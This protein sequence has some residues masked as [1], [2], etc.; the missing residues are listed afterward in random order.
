MN[1]TMMLLVAIAVTAFVARA[2]GLY[3]QA[4]GRTPKLKVPKLKTFS[5]V[6]EI[7]GQ[8]W[9]R[10]TLCT[11]Y[12]D[13][14]VLPVMAGGDTTTA[15][16]LQAHVTKMEAELKELHAA[17]TKYTAEVKE[18]GVDLLS[19]SEAFE[20]VDE[21][22]KA[23]STK[24]DEYEQVRARWERLVE[25]DKASTPRPTVQRLGIKQ[26]PERSA[27]STPEVPVRAAERILE[28]DAY[29]HLV[30][31]G[32]FDS[33][34]AF[35]ASRGLGPVQ[36]LSSD[37]ME[38][39]L[40]FGATTVTGGGATSAGPFI[41]SELMPGFVTYARKRPML[42]S[43]VGPGTTESDVVDYVK[44]SAPTDAAAETAEDAAA[45]ESTYAFSLETT[46]VREI[47][48]FVPI[49][50]RA[51]A[52]HGQMRTIIENELSMGALDR[53]DTQLATGSGSGQNLQGIY[54]ASGI[55]TMAAAGNKA[56]ALHRGITAIRVAA[57]VLSEPDY[58]GMHPNDF[59]D[60]VLDEDANGQF[61]FGNPAAGVPAR[62]IW[63]VPIAVSTVFTQNSPIVGDF[64]GSATL[65]I[66]EGLAV[67][68]GLNNDDFTKRRI[69]LLAAI[70]AAF[71]VKRAGG[72]CVITG[73]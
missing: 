9:R 1:G 36:M 6:P 49:T 16:D 34:A 52:D 17:A 32:A 22:W 46:N 73:Y 50:L 14:T 8:V 4:W 63:G 71:A 55:G 61:I 56:A 59:E 19:D 60:L 69:S 70:R 26:V 5:D 28:S 64:G 57:G 40:R 48:H 47:T 13:G 21:K 68:S 53:L 43:L 15:D 31:Q 23:Y 12:A 72:F 20:K 41:P 10:G 65:W 18:S 38:G 44:Q 3:V 11:L 54:N 27:D 24:A 39:L 7:V 30:E 45:P 42:A 67:S 62:T 35:I 25:I 51:M 66:R 29:T 37:E 33:E 2:E 58:I